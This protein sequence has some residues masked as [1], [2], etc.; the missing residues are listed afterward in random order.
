[1]NLKDVFE[2]LDL[3]EHIEGGYY[4]RCY[5]SDKKI[6]ANTD[7]A[8]ASSIYYL[9]TEKRPVGHFHKNT[10]DIL[11]FYHGGGTVLFHLLGKDGV[12]RTQILGP[13]LAEGHALQLLVAGGT[14]KA[15]ELLSGEFSLISE[16]VVPEFRFEDMVLAKQGDLQKYIQQHPL[17]G[18]FIKI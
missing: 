9:L 15:S 1:M 8:M 17:L 3:T 14:W 16:V 10:S 13:N 11:H 18:R 6:N 2:Y 5:C 4:R 7:Q 12:Y